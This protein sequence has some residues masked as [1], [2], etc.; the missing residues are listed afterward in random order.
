MKYSRNIECVCQNPLF[1][2]NVRPGS[3][4]PVWQ[5]Y[6]WFLQKK[7]IWY[8][9]AV[10]PNLLLSFLRYLCCLV[11]RR[12]EFLLFPGVCTFVSCCESLGFH[13]EKKVTLTLFILRRRI[14]NLDPKWQIPSTSPPPRKVCSLPII[15]A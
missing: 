6:R 15:I 7:N 11:G 3:V 13:S 4:K 14:D 5:D 9:L 1:S 2:E 10:M 12:Q 8:K